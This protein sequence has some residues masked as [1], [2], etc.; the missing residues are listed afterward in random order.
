M[1]N[2]LIEP[3][4][5]FEIIVEKDKKQTFYAL[6]PLTGDPL[7]I[8]FVNN[9]APD[10]DG[11]I[12]H[13]YPTLLLGEQNSIPGDIIYVFEGDGTTKGMDAGINLKD[14]QSLLGSAF[15]YAFNTK[16]GIQTLAAQTLK[17]P[18]ITSSVGN[19]INLANN[20]TINGFNVEV[21][22]EAAAIHAT[23]PSLNN[24]TV[25]NNNFISKGIATIMGYAI[26][27]DTGTTS[28]NILISN[29]RIEQFV[30]G[31]KM[32]TSGTYNL[33]ISNNM[34]NNTFS[35][36]HIQPIGAGTISLVV[37]KNTLQSNSNFSSAIYFF[38]T[39]LATLSGV[40]ENNTLNATPIGADALYF[41]GQGN[42]LIKNNI[43]NANP[44]NFAI[45]ITNPFA[46]NGLTAVVKNNTMTGGFNIDGNSIQLKILDNTSPGT[47]NFY[48]L[49]N[50]FGTM[51]ISSPDG[52][53]A[54]GT[55]NQNLPVNPSS[56][57]FPSG[58]PA[59]Y[60]IPQTTG[61]SF[62]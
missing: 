39:N 60:P 23:F 10:A 57:N 26:K 4:E 22:I 7:N 9:L 28:G 18:T 12:E 8:I 50:T 19:V 44:G 43:A 61:D 54:G 58:S 21:S 47:A 34:F 52:T 6:N 11:S 13:P 2:R 41:N 46:P 24:L 17:S 14:N 38:D 45:N 62:P 35:S 55:Y 5:R 27:L 20:N 37:N 1:Q 30:N 53:L 49:D 42:I 16:I 48:V 15:P 33:T 31:L 59:V 56:F 32:A 51:A 29:N 25:S 36:L 3:V 40:I